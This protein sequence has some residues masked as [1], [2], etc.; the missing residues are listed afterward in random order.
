MNL[1]LRR[2]QPV[3]CEER[4]RPQKTASTNHR[5]LEALLISAVFQCFQLCLKT[6]LSLLLKLSNK[7][8]IVIPKV[9]LRRST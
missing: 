5:V 6:L 7:F 3:D 9:S 4:R 8:R 2:H 1:N